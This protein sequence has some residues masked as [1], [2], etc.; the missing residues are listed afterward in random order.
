MLSR[1]PIK[2]LASCSLFELR[3]TPYIVHRYSNFAFRID[4]SIKSDSCAH[5]MNCI[6]L[7]QCPSHM[8]ERPVEIDMCEYYNASLGDGPWH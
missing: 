1:N 5:V 4:V 2:V 8:S 3:S 7:N 6:S